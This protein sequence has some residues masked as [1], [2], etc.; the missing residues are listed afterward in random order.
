[1]VKLEPSLN[2]FN[3]LLEGSKVLS[4]I[5]HNGVRIDVEKL[6]KTIEDALVEIS[7]I[8]EE[9]KKDDVYKIWKSEYRDEFNLDSCPQLGHIL[10]TKLKI[11][12]KSWTSGGASKK[13]KPSVS[14]DSLQDV[15]HPFVKKLFKAKHLKKTVNTFLKGMQKEVI[16]G[17][18]H[19]FY[20]L[21]TVVTYRSSSD[22]PNW[23]N[24]PRRDPAIAKLV[25]N[26]IIPRKGR[27][28]WELD[29]KG[30]EVCVAACVTKC[31]AL[32]EYVQNKKKDMHRDSAMDLYMLEEGQVHKAIRNAAKQW[33]VFAEFY[34]DYYIHCAKNL[35][36]VVD[37]E[38]LKL[39][40]GTPLRK[41]LNKIGIRELGECNPEKKPIEDTF[42]YHVRYVEDIFWNKRFV[43]YKDWKL[44]WWNDY[45]TNGELRLPTEFVVR[46][47][48]SGPLTKNE[49]VN[50]PIQ[51]GSFHC[52]LWT[53]IK[54]QKWI[55]RN[56]MKTYLLGQIHDS[57]I[58]DSPPDEIQD[59]LNEAY[60]IIREDLP[61]HFKWLIIP[62]ECEVEVAEIDKSWWD[63]KEWK[64]NGSGIWL[65]A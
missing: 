59:V 47:G 45:Q 63:K 58:G 62:M 29:F 17:Y 49:A 35:W 24:L 46:T 22:S 26:C 48:K 6:N 53:L 43:G 9:L 16:D 37:R 57:I 18:I 30:A 31:P 20:N 32:L 44:K 34:G 40:D 51:A 33:F 60:R 28:F 1:M 52:L 39:T 7:N 64:R 10:Y 14:E 11:P 61:K 23:Q 41:H 13:P 4:Q 25:R 5:E 38:E 15:N 42:E 2:A 50:V 3:L 65:A 19:P 21:H 27:H 55:N 12:C 8:E 36:E 54:L 56:K